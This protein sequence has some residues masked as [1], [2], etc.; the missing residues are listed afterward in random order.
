MSDHKRFGR[1]LLE[2]SGGQAVAGVLKVALPMLVA[3][4]L[5]PQEFGAYALVTVGILLAFNVGSLGIT[6]SSTFH[7]AGARWS[8]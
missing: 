2:V 5:D 3:R 8:S 6:A 1:A 4:R 7:A